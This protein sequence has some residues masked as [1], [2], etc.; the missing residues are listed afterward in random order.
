MQVGQRPCVCFQFSGRHSTLNTVIP[1]GS[2]Y[3]LTEYI[4]RAQ[5]GSHIPTLLPKCVL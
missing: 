5:M 2:I 4:L 3:L 1:S